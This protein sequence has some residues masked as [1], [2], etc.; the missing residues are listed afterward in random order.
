MSKMSQ[1]HAELSEQ[2][3]ELGFES[4][5]QAEANGY[6]IDY[7]GDTWILKPDVAKQQEQAHEAWLKEKQ[8]VLI[9]LGRLHENLNERGY[10]SLA[11][12]ADKATKFI[13]RGEV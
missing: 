11:D 7:N 12:V 4:I 8:E 2:A 3:Y 5:E 6:H 10:T 9:D 1:L 13:E